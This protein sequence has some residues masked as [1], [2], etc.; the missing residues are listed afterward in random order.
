MG[1]VCPGESLLDYS[2]LAL[3]QATVDMFDI[4][5]AGDGGCSPIVSDCSMDRVSERLG[6]F[7]LKPVEAGRALNQF[8]CLAETAG[9]GHDQLNWQL[10]HLQGGVG[11]VFLGAGQAH[12]GVALVMYVEEVRRTIEIRHDAVGDVSRHLALDILAAIQV[13]ERCGVKRHDLA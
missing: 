5:R 2:Y 7:G 1:Y 13:G 12:D 3:E 10:S 6:V 9:I 4:S 8:E 11:E